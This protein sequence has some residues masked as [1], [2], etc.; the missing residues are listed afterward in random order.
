MTLGFSKIVH[1]RQ[2]KQKG[3]CFKQGFRKLQ[4]DETH[5]FQSAGLE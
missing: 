1:T 5:L 2:T 4:L 3:M